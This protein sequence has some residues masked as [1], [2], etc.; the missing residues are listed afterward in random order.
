MTMSR[1]LGVK[2][3]RGTLASPRMFKV[4]PIEG[5]GHGCV[6]LRSIRMGE[7]I[8]A[9]RPLVVQGGTAPPLQDALAALTAEQLEMFW[10]LTQ[11][12]SRFGPVKN[13]GGIFATNAIP[14]STR[15][16][17][18]MCAVFPVAS[19]FN[20]ACSANATYKWNESLGSLTIHACK[21]VQPGEEICVN[22][23]FPA[24]CVLREQR[25]RRLLSTFGFLCTCAKCS[26]TGLAL[27]ASE[28]RLAE[29][30]DEH[31]LPKILNMLGQTENLARTSAPAVLRQLDRKLELIDEESQGGGHYQGLECF[32]QAFVEFCEAASARLT[33]VVARCPSGSHES[34]DSASSKPQ[35][36]VTFGKAGPDQ[37]QVALDEL[38]S[39]ARVYSEAACAYA[40]RARDLT[41]D[42]QGEDC[43]AFCVWTSTI[44]NHGVVGAP[45]FHERWIRAGLSPEVEV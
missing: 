9:D 3:E 33:Q 13:E 4:V 16:A 21:A 1:R 7:R 41:R 30:G 28:R 43:D 23:G 35:P 40:R 37:V 25:Q 10:T 11:N 34:T 38:K 26:L 24:G 17:T 29:I 14:F 45:F 8:L 19:R 42:I 31:A 44:A 2:G 39:R 6:A 36:M 27:D 12:E 20:H 32:L 15:V 5:K 22:Y 18:R